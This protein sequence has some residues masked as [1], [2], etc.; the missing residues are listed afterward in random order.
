MPKVTVSIQGYRET[1]ELEQ[2]PP[3]S[4]TYDAQIDFSKHSVP[5]S[6]GFILRP[7]TEKGFEC[8]IT[9]R[10]QIAPGCEATYGGHKTKSLTWK[11]YIEGVSVAFK[12]QL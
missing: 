12:V 11:G 5:F 9:L 10:L 4:G 2:F 7:K 8:F 1:A 6:V 3:E